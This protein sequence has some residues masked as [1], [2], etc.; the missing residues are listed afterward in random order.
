MQLGSRKP[1]TKV[2]LAAGQ[3]GPLSAQT[4]QCTVATGQ[5]GGAGKELA[6][7]LAAHQLLDAAVAQGEGCCD[8][9]NL[10]LPAQLQLV[11]ATAALR[12]SC[13]CI[14]H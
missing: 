2:T 4:P 10:Q 5:L 9:Y 7:Q 8:P 14:K 11:Q 3:Q 6:A 12:M 13:C 1:T